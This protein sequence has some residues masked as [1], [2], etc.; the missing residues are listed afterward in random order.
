MKNAWRYNPLDA[1]HRAVYAAAVTLLGSA[2][3]AI[4]YAVLG[5]PLGLG[6]VLIFFGVCFGVVHWLETRRV[7]RRFAGG[8]A[9]GAAD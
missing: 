7:R 4:V 8:R 2:F 1:A 6:S 9:T 3:L 5:I